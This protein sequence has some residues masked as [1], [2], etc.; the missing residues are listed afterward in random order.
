MG[1]ID[2]EIFQVRELFDNPGISGDEEG[3]SHQRS[4][5]M[6]VSRTRICCMMH[7]RVEHRLDP[8]ESATPV[9]FLE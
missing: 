3:W 5:Y 8:D 6:R 2:M 1:T 7:L 9:A 4:E